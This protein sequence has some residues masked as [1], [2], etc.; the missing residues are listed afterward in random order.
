MP[1]SHAR[2]DYQDGHGRAVA[3]VAVLAAI[4][5]LPLRLGTGTGSEP[6]PVRLLTV[7]SF[8]GAEG[9]P[10]AL[11]PDGNFVAFNWTGPDFS[12]D[13]DLWV[14]AV[15]GN[16]LVRLTSTPDI[17]ELF[18]SWSPDGRLIAFT[19]VLAGVGIGIHVVSPLGGSARKIIDSALGAAWLPDSRSLVYFAR[20]D[21]G[22]ALFHHV[23]TTGARRQLTTPPAGFSDRDPRVSPDGRSVAFV[24][25]AG[26][27]AFGGA[28]KAALFVVPIAGGEAVR[29]DDWVRTVA[30][31]SWTPDGREILFTRMAAGGFTAF[32]VAAAGGPA[33]PA[34]GLPSDAYQLST[35]GYRRDGSFRVAVVEAQSDVGLRMIDLHAVQPGG[36]VTSWTAF[37]D[38]TRRDWPGRFSRDGTQV[39]LTSDRDGPGRV[40]VASRDGSR[41]RTVTDI[42]GTSVGS[43][44][45]SPD[46]RSLVFDAVDRENLNDLFVTGLEGEPLIRLTHDDQSE[47]NPAWSRDGGWIYYESNA[48]GRPEI[49]KIAVSR[50]NPHP[51][52]HAG[53]HGPSRVSGWTQRLFSP[54]RLGPI[55][56][57]HGQKGESR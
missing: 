46:G 24:R 45:W 7:T 37:C 28:S 41:L 54:T 57:N 9:G 17:S 14:K 4:A 48:S 52:H 44:A 19:Q 6:L 25:T 50:W 36:R 51:A 16:A 5:W 8:P 3:V 27:G 15:E 35:S 13:G 42:D 12:A 20:T 32:R 10:P 49:W 23:L 38:S 47:I 33:T 1:T 53:R 26:I 11:S 56:V 30:G 2:G 55:R 21:K 29:V 39:A 18:P 40:Y 43:A 22:L 31:P 34:P